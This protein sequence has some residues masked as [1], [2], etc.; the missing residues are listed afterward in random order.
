MDNTCQGLYHSRA[1]QDNRKCNQHADAIILI[2]FNKLKV[3][4]INK[5]IENIGQK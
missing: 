3:E 4:G 2:N 5:R 1:T